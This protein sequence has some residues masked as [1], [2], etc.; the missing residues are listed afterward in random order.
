MQY[1]EGLDELVDEVLATPEFSKDLLEKFNRALFEDA[2]VIPLYEIKKIAFARA[3][4][5]DDR[6]FGYGFLWDWTPADAWI[7]ESAR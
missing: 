6:V 1:P 3:G 5:H 4:V 2:T 7:E